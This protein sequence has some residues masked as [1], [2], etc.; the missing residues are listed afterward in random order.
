MTTVTFEPAVIWDLTEK[1]EGSRGLP[2]DGWG[3]AHQDQLSI[4]GQFS[5]PG[6]LGALSLQKSLITHHF[7]FTLPFYQTLEGIRGQMS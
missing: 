1:A 3:G 7:V 6:G 5:G 2:G 4:I